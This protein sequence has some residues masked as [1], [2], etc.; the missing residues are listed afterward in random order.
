MS[1][2]ALRVLGRSSLSAFAALLDYPMSHL[3]KDLRLEIQFQGRKMQWEVDL[4]LPS[5]RLLPRPANSTTGSAMHSAPPSEISSFMLQ[6][7][8]LQASRGRATAKLS[9]FEA[10]VWIWLMRAKTKPSLFASKLRST[11][12]SPSFLLFHKSQLSSSKRFRSMSAERSEK[13]TSQ[14]AYRVM[15]PAPTL[16]GCSEALAMSSNFLLML[17]G[18][19]SRAVV[20]LGAGMMYEQHRCPGKNEKSWAVTSRPTVLARFFKIS[21]KDGPFSDFFDPFILSQY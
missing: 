9:S 18:F 11:S 1:S 20:F 7:T 3:R 13:K 2:L 17:V 4:K 8:R 5:A 21:L 15:R 19:L 14:F 10:E 6:T 16:A 12:P